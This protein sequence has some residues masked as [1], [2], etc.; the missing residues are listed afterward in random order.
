MK[1]ACLALLCAS[2]ASAATLVNSYR[3]ATPT[4]FNPPLSPI[5]HETFDAAGY[6]LVGWAEGVSGGTVDEDYTTAPAPLEGTQSLRITRPIGDSVVTGLA[7]TD[8]AEITIVFRMR[9]TDKS[10]LDLEFLRINDVFGVRSVTVNK[11]A[12]DTLIIYDS[13][14]FIDTVATIS[15]DVTYYVWIHCVKGTGANGVLSIAFSTDGSRPTSGTNFAQVSNGA[16]TVDFGQVLFEQSSVGSQ[17]SVI[18]FDDLY[19]DDATP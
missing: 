10:T 8:Q 14:A 7:F 5:V 2:S 3:F 15:Q 6:D 1:L 4:G 11:T 9:F 13:T 18:I 12:T 16:V 17:T 19:V